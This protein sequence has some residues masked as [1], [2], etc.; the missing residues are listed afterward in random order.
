MARHG[1]SMAMGIFFLMG[2]LPVFAQ[3]TSPAFDCAGD[4]TSTE[5][6]VCRSDALASADRQLNDLYRQTLTAQTD[7]GARDRLKSGQKAFL[8]L[9]NACKSDQRCILATYR[10]R[11][12]DL[13]GAATQTAL[14]AEPVEIRFQFDKPIAGYDISGLWFPSLAANASAPSGPAILRLRDAETGEVTQIAENAL[15]LVD[16]TASQI[17]LSHMQDV[18][19]LSYSAEDA[20]TRGQCHDTQ[21]TCL[22]LGDATIDLQDLDFDGKPDLVI[23]HPGAG[24][25]GG[26]AYSVYAIPDGID[27][28]EGV[29]GYRVFARIDAM[30]AF[31]LGKHEIEVTNSDGACASSIETYAADTI[32]PFSLMRYRVDTMDANGSCVTKDYRVETQDSG[33]VTYTPRE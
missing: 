28:G 1:I 8:K 14:A 31:N 30:T 4:M 33:V 23:A 20:A 26:T 25:R 18:L 6:A 32:R 9:R 13:T 19:R 5:K 22:W 27:L 2:V 16:P 12:A 11:T 7:Q 29:W 24:Q 17:D 3:T 21:D 15:S 10:A